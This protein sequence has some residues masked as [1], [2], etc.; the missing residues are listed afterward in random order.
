MIAE[1]LDRRFVL[2][3]L[4]RIR[5]DLADRLSERRVRGGPPPVDHAQA[6][7]DTMGQSLSREGAAEAEAISAARED[8]VLVR[9]EEETGVLVEDHI[10]Y[11]PRDPLVSVMQSFME[12]YVVEHRPELL[13]G[14]LEPGEQRVRAD[15]LSDADLPAVTARR[16]KLDEPAGPERVRLLERFS[17][18]DPL[19][20]Q[21]KL[22]E[23]FTRWNEP[24][25]FRDAEQPELVDVA[26]DARLILVGDWA[27]G[28]E[29]AAHIAGWMRRY[30]EQAMNR[31][32]EVH[33]VHLGDTYYSGWRREYRNHLLPFWP[34]WPE[35]AGKRTFS[36]TLNG[37]HDMYSGGDGYFELLD[38]ARFAGHGGLSFFH[39]RNANWDILGLDTA[40]DD[41]RLAGSQVGWIEGVKAESTR[42][43]FMMSHHQPFSGRSEGG[44]ELRA[45]LVNVLD[46]DDPLDLWFWGH[47]HR[48]AHYDSQTFGLRKGRLLGHGGVPVWQFRRASASNPPPES[49]EYREKRTGSHL[50][51]WARFGFAVLDLEG[52]AIAARYVDEHGDEYRT[53]RLS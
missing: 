36:W 24:H 41:H 47:E 27:S 32:Q 42:K 16:L 8:A 20:V 13:E 11:L 48:H 51:P 25:E 50:Q 1:I 33:V 38:D 44:T 7:I 30:V 10:A 29:R 45:Q 35:D 17:L 3:E 9:S 21:S 49:W 28:I 40:Y 52:P 39:L 46:D 19:W 6:L 37:N 2:A 22:S 53:E 34:L 12:E 5:D 23:W 43:T 26:D 4:A 15:D 31:G 14:N 18:T